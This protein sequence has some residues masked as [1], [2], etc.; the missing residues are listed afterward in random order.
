VSFP[1]VF[2]IGPRQVEFYNGSC[3]YNDAELEKDD[4]HVLADIVGDATG[5]DTAIARG[6]VGRYLIVILPHGMGEVE[7]YI[8]QNKFVA[9]RIIPVL[10]DLFQ[11]FGPNVFPLRYQLLI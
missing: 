5:F 2:R 9:N 3:V 7:V 1:Y 11:D 6:P 10:G 4:L 8:R